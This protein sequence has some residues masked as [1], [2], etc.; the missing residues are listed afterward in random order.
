[1]VR[2]YE[3][4]YAVRELIEEQLDYITCLKLN[5][6]TYEGELLEAQLELLELE[7]R[8]NLAW[9]DWYEEEE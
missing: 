6:D 3:N 5:E 8:E 2:A 7:Q 4:P 1:M 9:Q